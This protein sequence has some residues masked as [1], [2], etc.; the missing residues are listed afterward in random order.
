M[1][2]ISLLIV[3]VLI[4]ALTSPIQSASGTMPMIMGAMM[5]E[6]LLDD[7]TFQRGGLL[8]IT[9]AYENS[10]VPVYLLFCSGPEQQNWS[11][12]YS[13]VSSSCHN[14]DHIDC[15]LVVKFSGRNM[16]ISHT[17]ETSD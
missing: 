10:D 13:S 5:H 4:A 6:N 15:E 1:W 3:V 17:V 7:F 2:K 8:D 11:N 9:L 12:R 14:V 16:S